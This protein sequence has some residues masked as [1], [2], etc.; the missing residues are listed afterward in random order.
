MDA[1]ARFDAD[2]FFVLRELLAPDRAL[3]L[4]AHIDTVRGTARSDGDRAFN[5]WEGVT[6]DPALW[7][8]VTDPV[9]VAAVRAV[10]GK[11]L[12]YAR[13]SEVQAD[14]AG[15][16]WHRDSIDQ[17]P[18]RGSDWD[19]SRCPYRI[20]RACIFLQTQA[21]S[22][23]AFGVVPGSHRRGVR[24]IDGVV[25]DTARKVSG[26]LGL[27]W[28]PRRRALPRLSMGDGWAKH[29]RPTQPTWIPVGLGDC[30]VI[31]QR[32]L[33]SPS[34]ARGPQYSIYFSYG[35]Q[36]EHTH[37]LWRYYRYGSP[38]RSFAPMPTELKQRLAQAELLLQEEACGS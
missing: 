4:R 9:L 1:A 31:H 20:V 11:D 32:V 16:I 15:Y 36:D 35:T 12:R 23:F 37:R 30:V 19:E 2:G 34:P 3:A 6:F 29:W 38:D 17:V 21:E 26:R 14:N 28:D 8:V 24:T 5:R 22:G 10:V 33:H 25:L 7:D 27:A 18:G 13:N